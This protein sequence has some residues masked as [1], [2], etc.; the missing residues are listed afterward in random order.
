MMRKRKKKGEK[1]KIERSRKVFRGN[2]VGAKPR[3][4]KK[5]LRPSYP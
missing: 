3:R 2:T 1:K 5:N 4:G